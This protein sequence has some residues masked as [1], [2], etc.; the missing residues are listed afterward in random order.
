M[1][2]TPHRRF[3]VLR[4]KALALVSVRHVTR[5]VKNLVK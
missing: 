1:N 4:K 5:L 2:G 3:A